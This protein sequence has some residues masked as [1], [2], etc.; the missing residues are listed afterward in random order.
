MSKI[1]ELLKKT[2]EARAKLA[3]SGSGVPPQSPASQTNTEQPSGGQTVSPS[4]A[5]GHGMVARFQK[6]VREDAWVRYR[7]PALLFALSLFTVIFLGSLFLPPTYRASTTIIVTEKKKLSR[8]TLHV[9][10]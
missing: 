1:T 2:E 3:Q 8:Y 6:L 4:A 5:K 7:G 9:Q 10:R